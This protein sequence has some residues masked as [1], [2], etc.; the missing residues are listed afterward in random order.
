[1]KKIILSLAVIASASF[2]APYNQYQASML[3]FT[4]AGCHATDG[5]SP[6][7]IPPINGQSKDYIYNTLIDYKTGERNGTIMMKHV[8]GFTDAELEQIAYYFSKVK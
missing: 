7:S 8:K 4:C 2:A 1:M 3:S 5:K 6:G